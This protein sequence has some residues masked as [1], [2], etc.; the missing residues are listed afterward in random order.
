MT[1][2]QVAGIAHTWDTSASILITNGI[3]YALSNKVVIYGDGANIF[4]TFDSFQYVYKTISGDFDLAVRVEAL[5][6]TDNNARAG[7]MAR[8]NAFQ[9]SPNVLIEA[10]PDRFILQYRTNTA[11]A[12]L[13]VTSPRPPTAFP[14]CWI[15][16]VRS[17]TVFTGYSGTNF[18]VW[19]LIGSFDTSIGTTPY[20]SDALIGLVASAGNAANT[21]RAQFSGFGPAV[22]A[23]TLSIQPSGNL[24]E[25]N[26]TSAQPTTGFFLQ[27]TPDLAS[28]NSWTN[29]PNSE[30]TNRLFV[31]PSA[32]ALFY[33]TRYPVSP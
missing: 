21:T 30:T 31:S 11:E 10:T 27:A 17:G 4:G 1:G 16:L 23:P 15:R 32:N 13:T 29:V 20:N 26:W 33:R 22:V 9:D 12:T 28:P 3:A 7:L 19:D 6:R 24:L 2:A 8:Q 5:I 25:I 14:N 18:G